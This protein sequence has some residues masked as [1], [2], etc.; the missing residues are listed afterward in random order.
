MTQLPLLACGNSRNRQE[1]KGTLA[2]GDSAWPGRFGAPGLGYRRYN[3]NE[4]DRAGAAGARERSSRRSPAP[5]GWLWRPGR[6][7][8]ACDPSAVVRSPVRSP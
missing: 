6:E 8:V 4:S 1:G 5:P 7:A 3:E 2:A